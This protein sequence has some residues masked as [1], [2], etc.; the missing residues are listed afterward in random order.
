M[1]GIV[2]FVWVSLIL[3][4]LGWLYIFLPASMAA[5]RGRSAFGW[6]L[7][8]LFISPFFTIIALLV[9]GPTVETALARIQEEEG[10]S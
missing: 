3:I 7:L 1:D 5:E 10:S 4:I 9:L 6:V 2:G 8:T